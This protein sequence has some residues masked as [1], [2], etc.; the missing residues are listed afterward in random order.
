MHPGAAPV[1]LL[2]R[3]GKDRHDQS[4]LQS[5]AIRPEGALLEATFHDWR[6]RYAGLMPPELNR[7]WQLEDENVK[8]KKIVED[9]TFDMAMLQDIPRQRKF[10]SPENTFVLPASIS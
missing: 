2:H 5:D 8:I 1:F 4:G 7:L 9:R 3:K 6:K 10:G